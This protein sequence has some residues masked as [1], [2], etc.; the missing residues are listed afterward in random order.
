MKKIFLYAAIICLTLGS[1][2]KE[3]LIPEKDQTS[4]EGQLQME[5]GNSQLQTSTSSS[6]EAVPFNDVQIVNFDGQQFHNV[7]TNETMTST[8]DAQL[9]I[10]GVYNGNLSTMIIH[11][12]FLGIKGIGETGRQYF[13]SGSTNRKTF[14]FSNGV[15]ATKVVAIVRWTTAGSDNDFIQEATFYIKVDAT[16]AVTVLKETVM[17]SYCQ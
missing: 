17:E 15:L 11:I 2:K 10:H 1:C 4:V 7:C 8:G 6:G 12:N 9:R 3:G 14:T 5:S 16:G 13:I